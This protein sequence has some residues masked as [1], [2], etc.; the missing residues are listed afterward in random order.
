M[1]DGDMLMPAR[2]VLERM[3]T[4]FSKR[5]PTPISHPANGHFITISFGN[6]V[7][8]TYMYEFILV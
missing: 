6:A 5:Q 1:H 3:V 7:G 4:M 8:Y 2:Q